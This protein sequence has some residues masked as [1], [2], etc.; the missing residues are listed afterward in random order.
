MSFNN[1]AVKSAF[2]AVATVAIQFIP[3]APAAI[4]AEVGTPEWERCV[5]TNTCADSTPPY[6]PEG[7]LERSQGSGT[8][9]L[10][11]IA[12]Q[13]TKSEVGSAEWERCVLVPSS[14]R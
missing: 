11:A 4:A 5:L 9:S 7:G 1:I 2:A 6:A 12:T 13:Q 3:A 8:R 14:C 10:K